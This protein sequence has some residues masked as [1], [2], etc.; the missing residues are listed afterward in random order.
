MYN[1]R[2]RVSI[3][4]SEVL[5]KL[6]E[7]SLCGP[8]LTT[9]VRNV[10]YATTAYL[11]EELIRAAQVLVLTKRVSGFVSGRIQKKLGLRHRRTPEKQMSDEILFPHLFPQF[12]LTL[13]WANQS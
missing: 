12:V 6:P 7:V 8:V 10:A 11:Y 3:H 4:Q 2:V 5:K 9:S 13:S 1:E